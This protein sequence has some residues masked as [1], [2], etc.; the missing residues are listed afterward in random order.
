MLYVIPENNEFDLCMSLAGQYTDDWRFDDAIDLIKGAM[1][2]YLRRYPS[3]KATP[4][5][6]YVYK[7]TN[8][9]MGSPVQEGEKIKLT[10]EGQTGHYEVQK[11][12]ANGYV[13][14]Q[15]DETGHQVSIKQE[16]LHE[17]FAEEHKPAIEEARTRLKTNFE[18][19]QKH[20]SEVQKEKAR[21]ALKG[22][23]DRFTIKTP[24]R[25]AK[26]RALS[27]TVLTHSEPSVENHLAAADA[28]LQ[29]ADMGAPNA[30]QHKE[31]ATLHKEAAKGYLAINASV[32][33]LKDPDNRFH[34]PADD[35]NKAST[36]VLVMP[37]K[38]PRQA[39]GAFFGDKARAYHALQVTSDTNEQFL[40]QFGH[41]DDAYRKWQEAVAAMPSMPKVEGQKRATKRALPVRPMAWPGG[42]LDALNEALEL[43][44]PKRIIGKQAKDPRVTSPAEA[45]DRLVKGD[46]LWHSANTRKAVGV[47][48]QWFKE[49]GLTLHL[50]EEAQTAL[51]SHNLAQANAEYASDLG[52]EHEATQIHD[53]TQQAA[54]DDPTF[55]PDAIEKDLDTD[56]DF[57][58]NVEA[59]DEEPHEAY[60]KLGT[61]AKTFK[62]FFGDYENDPKNASKVINAKG[63]PAEQHNMAPMPVYH[64]TAVGGFSSFDPAKTSSYN[65]FGEGFYFTEDKGIAKEY[66]EKDADTAKWGSMHGITDASGKE[67]SHLPTK[68][69]EQVIASTPGYGAIEEEA[70]T[71]RDRCC[72]AAALKRATDPQGVNVVKFLQEY[73]HPSGPVLGGN[74]RPLPGHNDGSSAGLREYFMKRLAK[75]KVGDYQPAITPPQV[76][77]CYLNVRKPIDMEAPITREDFGDL[78]GYLQERQKDKYRPQYL[79][80]TKPGP[81]K[82]KAHDA[83]PFY[84]KNL[85]DHPAIREMGPDAYGKNFSHED[86][87]T[88][89]KHLRAEKKEDGS[90]AHGIFHLTDE[91]TLTWGD[92]HYI[93]TDGH[94]YNT[95]KALFKDWAQKR[96][97][98]GIAHTG[99]WNVGTKAHK[100][101]IAW[102]PNQI[103]AVGNEGTFNPTSNDI[104][105]SIHTFVII[106]EKLEKAER[107]S[108]RADHD[109]IKR[110]GVPG[111]YKYTYA[112]DEQG[113]QQLG[114]FDRPVAKPAVQ[115]EQPKFVL[116]LP[117]KQ[118]VVTPVTP[119]QVEKVTPK[120]PV[121]VIPE[122]LTEASKPIVAAPAKIAEAKPSE[123]TTSAASTIP[124]II[125]PVDT[126]NIKLIPATK[127]TE[128]FKE[129]GEKTSADKL[130]KIM[131]VGEHIWGS[132][133]DLRRMQINS[134]KD[135]EALTFDEAAKLISKTKLIPTQDLQTLKALGMS[136]GTAHM[137]LAFLGAIR[138][139]SG[140]TKAE[141]M[142]YVD[143]VKEVCASLNACRN[144]TDVW[145]LQEEMWQRHR[146]AKEWEQIGLSVATKEEVFAR[147]KQLEKDN[148]GKIYEAKQ[149]S[150]TG[151]YYVA[152]RL[153]QPYES[154]GNKFLGFLVHKGGD[155][156]DAFKEA[157]TADNMWNKTTETG[158]GFGAEEITDGWAYLEQRGSK[159]ADEAKQKSAKK[160]IGETKRGQSW[161]KEYVSIVGEAKRKGGVPMRDANAE[162]TKKTFHLKELD[163]GTEGY[164][165]Q[166]DREFH[167]SQIEAALHDLTDVLGIPKEQASF[168]G[169]LGIAAGARGSMQSPLAHYEVDRFVINLTKMRG[170]AALAHEWGHA[171]DNVLANLYRPEKSNIRHISEAPEASHWPDDLK[172]SYLK[173][174]K[175]MCEHPEPEK[176][177]AEHKK[178]LT[179]LKVQESKLSVDYYNLEKE[180]NA[181]QRKVDPEHVPV[182]I[183]HHET[184]IAEWEKELEPLQAKIDAAKQKGKP[185]SP[186]SSSVVH[187]ADNRKHWIDQ[188]EKAIVELKA[189]TSVK[190]PDDAKKLEEITS[191][192]DWLRPQVNKL[193][194]TIKQTAA[195][196]PTISNYKRGSTM[197]GGNWADSTEML[198]RVFECYTSDKLEKQGRENTYLVSGKRTNEM[199]DTQKAMPDGSQAQPFPHG[200]ERERVISAIDEFLNV[201]RTKGHLEK[202]LRFLESQ[203]LQRFT[204]RADM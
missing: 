198:A 49:H 101:W 130:E 135:L 189:G 136:P 11:V 167:T 139:K 91:N 51:E 178:H 28:H 38:G 79:G 114:L 10:H 61:K 4:R 57:G 26:T 45:W 171:L 102:Q 82:W 152:E 32:T 65:I 195:F 164:M 104:Y 6:Y 197:L 170:G 69:A 60:Q 87:V 138:G 24:E 93:M 191:R 131:P 202:A 58:F 172:A 108:Q 183:T 161:A 168:N 153:P 201:L 46:K 15:H 134:S 204:I 86:F 169:R 97:Y 181:T 107:G 146:K 158:R 133:K 72:V 33:A 40:G 9:H 64:G 95:E 90:P 173:L 20:G 88:A 159:K 180:H 53:H 150:Y 78:S 116:P 187:E 186:F 188:Y 94:W 59:T 157:M 3:G 166:A 137:N 111:H 92:V 115:P 109:Y 30:D 151:P 7:I 12:H 48:T 122:M 144:L 41:A 67:V 21:E 84:T 73:R 119:P 165:T 156:S 121:K 63:E 113:G 70:Y 177:K 22:H 179:E 117:P 174:H 25:I 163:Y 81:D 31:L 110:E 184:R 37:R 27:L 182:R 75:D 39:K 105:K 120:E 203:P 96:G 147:K 128:L 2:K 132:K 199:Y 62:G 103:K 50:P 106:P 125:K 47:F 43:V 17:M 23:E 160:R 83:I 99:G 123:A 42:E 142:Q 124:E 80:D 44:K 194:D 89:K 126:A 200:A 129:M 66:T 175:A 36:P 155:W 118:E 14:M 68:W 1:H 185:L 196:D 56:F 8:K 5:W 190:H 112:T 52:G 74:G 19:A 140:T 176:A 141:Q 154:L 85:N 98:D 76:F 55:N 100:V 148:P 162:R 54:D 192:L 35:A 145:K 18:E 34:V 71:D 16:H 149:E 193:R 127:P 29:A 13:T 77:E 143:E